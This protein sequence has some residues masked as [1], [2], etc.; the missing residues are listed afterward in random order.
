MPR[1][2][3][4]RVNKRAKPKVSDED[5]CNNGDIENQRNKLEVFLRDFDIEGKKTDLTLIFKICNTI[6]FGV[7]FLEASCINLNKA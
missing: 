7:K 1:K 4:T 3:N 5:I 2:R 6:Y